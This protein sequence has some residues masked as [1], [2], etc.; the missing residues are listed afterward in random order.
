MADP[1]FAGQRHGAR[2]MGLS[3]PAFLAVAC[4]GVMAADLGAL[5][6]GLTGLF[7]GAA[8]AI[9]AWA[10]LRALEHARPFVY[11]ELG[12]WVRTHGRCATRRYWGASTADPMKRARP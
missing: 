12:V 8:L 9:V 5:I 11:G 3:L 1:T 7:A 10:G 4:A 6:F 2:P